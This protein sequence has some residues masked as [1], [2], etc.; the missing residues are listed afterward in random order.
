M[1]NPG[2]LSIGDISSAVKDYGIFVTVLFLGWKGRGIIQPG[3][4]LFK[5]LSG[6]IDKIDS[7]LPRA[8]QHMAFMEG[9]MHQLLNNHLAHLKTEAES[10]EKINGEAVAPD[11]Q[12]IA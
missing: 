9:S 12:R 6:F 4:D 10:S 8:D 2:S 1:F 11:Y 7:R 3:I 5:K